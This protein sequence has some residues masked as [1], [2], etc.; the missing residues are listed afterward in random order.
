MHLITCTSTEDYAYI[1]LFSYRWPFIL[2]AVLLFLV[3]Y[4]ASTGHTD[5]SRAESLPG[6]MPQKGS[7]SSSDVTIVAQTALFTGTAVEVQVNVTARAADQV[8]LEASIPPFRAVLAGIPG[9]SARPSGPTGTKVRFLISA[10]PRDEWEIEL[11]ITE[12]EV[13]AGDGGR[14]VVAGSW[15]LP[16]QA[17]QGRAAAAA[18]SV[19]A[20]EPVTT[21]VNG[22][23]LAVESYSMESATVI[24]Y[25]LSNAV[26]LFA[27]PTLKS[28]TTLLQ[29]ER[30]EQREDGMREVWYRAT[31]STEPLSLIFS[32]L[33][34]PDPRDRPGL[35][36]SR[37]Q[38]S[39]NLPTPVRMIQ[40]RPISSGYASQNPTGRTWRVSSG[41]GYRMIPACR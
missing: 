3:A 13:Q 32:E 10:W 18:R 8:V 27:Q 17:P 25:W 29:P 21:D 39:W 23:E 38:N 6:V 19:T 30:S 33:M 22:Y 20:M 34:A 4:I 35:S 5:E 15:K 12:V 7:A 31:S 36:S 1:E 2:L 28:G 26:R 41:G 11:E 9:E 16:I 37:W 24:R 40:L 14:R